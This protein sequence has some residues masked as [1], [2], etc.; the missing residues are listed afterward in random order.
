MSSAYP[1]LSFV[2]KFN[3]RIVFKVLQPH[4]IEEII[5]EL[6]EKSVDNDLGTLYYDNNGVWEIVDYYNF[7]RKHYV[8][9]QKY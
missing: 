9:K 3:R 8:K 6:L 2:D 5:L 1:L 7:E 4:R